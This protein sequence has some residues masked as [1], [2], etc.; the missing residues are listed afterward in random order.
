MAVLESVQRGTAATCDCVIEYSASMN[1]DLTSPLLAPTTII[2]TC[3]FHEAETDAATLHNLIAIEVR[4]LAV[5]RAIIRSYFARLVDWKLLETRHVEILVDDTLL[6]SPDSTALRLALG[7][8][9]NLN[10]GY[11]D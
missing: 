9:T 1:D 4:P 7:A 8:I 10:V 2:S 6:S 11:T 5:S 3:T